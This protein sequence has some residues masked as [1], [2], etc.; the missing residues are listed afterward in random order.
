MSQTFS[1]QETDVTLVGTRL[2]ISGSTCELD[3]IL[4]VDSLRVPA[5]ATGPTLMT[6]VG[7]L[8]LASGA[9]QA[10]LNGIL[11]GAA[12]LLAAAA[13]WTQKKP[14]Y[15]LRLQTV[16]G[17]STELQSPDE[18]FINRVVKEVE[19]ARASHRRIE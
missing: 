6:V 8:C 14:T 17:E 9:G 10:G 4:S 19:R 3:E 12:L 15:K 16:S 13:W 2:T 11:L 7:V 1:L 5:A 18:E